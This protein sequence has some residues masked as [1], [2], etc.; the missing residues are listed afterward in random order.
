MTTGTFDLNLEANSRQLL[1]RPR[2]AARALGI[3][4][5]TLWGLDVPR[6][7]IGRRGVRYFVDD[8]RRWI[9]SQRSAEK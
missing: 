5:R 4:E 6:I 1:L 9:E 2:E 3:S 8:L 7:R